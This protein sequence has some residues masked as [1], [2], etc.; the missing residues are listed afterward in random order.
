MKAFSG[1]GKYT[2][3]TIYLDGVEIKWVV[4]ADDEEGYVVVYKTKLGRFDVVNGE[5]IKEIL[6]GK[7]EI[8]FEE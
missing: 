5:I 2:N 3:A 4:E 8:K 7:V 1:D 6:H